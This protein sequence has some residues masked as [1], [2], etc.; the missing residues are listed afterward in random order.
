MDY[1]AIFHSP[2]IPA[3]ADALVGRWDR[4]L[5]DQSLSKLAELL[6]DT[7]Y[8]ERLRFE[9]ERGHDEEVELI[10]HA[11]RAIGSGGRGPL[12]EA[13]RALVR[14][15]AHEI[16]HPFS[17]RAYGVATRL[18]PNALT[19]LVTATDPRRLLLRDL[20]PGSRIGI[21]GDVELI[22]RL[23]KTST[24]ILA[25]THLSNLDSPLIGYVLYRSGL[26]PFAYGAGLNLFSNPMMAFWMSRLGAYTVDRRKQGRIYKDTLKDYSTELLQRGCHSLFFPGGTRSRS[27]RIEKSVKKGL[28]GTG[29]QAW[30]ETLAEGHTRDVFVVPLTLSTSLVLEAETLVRDSLSREGKQRYIIVDDEFSQPRRVASYLRRVA[31]LDEAV[32]VTFGTPLDLMGNPVDAEGHSLGPQGQRIDRRR[33]VCDGEGEVQW[34]PQRD[35]VYTERL[36]RKLVQAYHRDNVALS[37][38]VAALAAWRVLCR[39]NPGIDTWQL[40]RL[41]RTARSL[42]RAEVQAE[43]ARVLEEIGALQQQERIRTALPRQAEEVLDTAMT[44]FASYHSRPAIEVRG[45]DLEVDP[46]LLHFYRNRLTGYGLEG[47]DGGVA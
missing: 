13:I 47:A 35:R 29:L 7:V 25:P 44:R 3:V 1:P 19:N 46:E 14:S 32:H 43:V 10:D 41:D 24:I 6:A 45:Q 17:E 34:D 37:T 2:S 20:D 36:S 18:L 15:Y 9:E 39:A 12:L 31:N 11:A 8:R 27:G 5:K 16:H 38:H 33:Y 21:H 40:V 42:M 23:A 4:R 22:Q 28:L 30:Q 26:P